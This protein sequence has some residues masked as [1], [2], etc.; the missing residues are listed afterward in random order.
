MCLPTYDES[1]EAELGG[2][3]TPLTA[4]IYH[5][6]PADT[7]CVAFRDQLQKLVDWLT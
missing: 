4:F 1:H 3:G 6:D 5:N 7:S 2:N